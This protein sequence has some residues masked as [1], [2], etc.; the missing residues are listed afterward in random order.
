MHDLGF[1]PLSAFAGLAVPA[2]AAGSVFVTDR[3]GMGFATVLVRKGRTAALATRVRDRFGIELPGDARRAA[4][5]DIAFA[6]IGRGAW[7]ASN[8]RA[9]EGFALALRHELGDLASVSDQSDGYAA[10][11]LSGPKARATLQKLVSIDLHPAVFM[12][13]HVAA[14]LAAH[15]SINLWRLEDTADGSAVFEL[16]VFRSLSHSLWHALANSAAEF[17][18]VVRSPITP[19][20]VANRVAPHVS[21]VPV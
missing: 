4:A 13:G 20:P 5:R 12:P 8:E 16:T 21:E 14:T 3:D 6:G 10:L 15:M 2:D 1:T 19:A 11:R 17:G 7:L 18:L 9:G